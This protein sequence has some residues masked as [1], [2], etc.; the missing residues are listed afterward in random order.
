MG[1]PG[2]TLR[3]FQLKHSPKSTGPTPASYTS[4]NN[5]SASSSAA[6]ASSFTPPIPQLP[7]VNVKLAWPKGTYDVVAQSIESPPPSTAPP[8]P[9]P[10]NSPKIC[11]RAIDTG[12]RGAPESTQ[13]AYDVAAST[14]HAGA[15]ATQTAPII[16]FNFPYYDYSTHNNSV[17]SSHFK[18][19]DNSTHT[20]TLTSS[21]EESRAG[22]QELNPHPAVNHPPAR[23]AIP[24]DFHRSFLA[25]LATRNETA[26]SPIAQTWRLLAPVRE[27]VAQIFGL[28]LPPEGAASAH[29]QN[30]QPAP[31][32]GTRVHVAEVEA[33]HRKPAQKAINED[34]QRV[35]SLFRSIAF[36]CLFSHAC[37]CGR[38]PHP[39]TPSPPLIDQPS[40]VPC[41]SPSHSASYI[42]T[43]LDSL[44]QPPIIHLHTSYP[45]QLNR[46][47]LGSE[48]PTPAVFLC[49][50]SPQPSP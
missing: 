20:T 10:A 4:N 50:P 19:V 35:G 8:L 34:I 30:A 21:I 16:N 33:K 11:A 25:N 49:T 38:R 28:S 41:S 31:S 12:S 44:Q 13:K 48:S 47:D 39:T 42:F 45:S 32:E 7:P 3:S 40:P 6:D 46:T 5:A 1:D 2:A 36:I 37:A 43:G 29:A 26:S 14:S 9:S 22:L 18:S 23:E 15:Q 27:R 24:N 17:D